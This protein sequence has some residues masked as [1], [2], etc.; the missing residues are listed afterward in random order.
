MPIVR[1]YGCNACGRFTEV[2]LTLEQSED[3]PPYCPFCAVTQ[4][5]QEFKPI[6]I[7]GSTAGKAHKLAEEI[8]R[9]DYGVANMQ[10][11]LREGST[12]KVRYKDQGTPAQAGTWGVA[13]GMLEKA[14]ATGRQTRMANGGYSGLDTLQSMLKSGEQPD[15]IEA[16]KRKAM[17]VW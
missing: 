6:A 17:R 2:T 13:G 8:A 15:L 4:M 3:P 14:I 11:D 7:G 12:P 16:S 9:E 5:Q 1:T 10:R